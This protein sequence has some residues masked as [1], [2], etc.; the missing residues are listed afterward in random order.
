MPLS[1]QQISET[2]QRLDAAEQ[3][4]QQTGLISLAYPNMT[5]G[6]AYAIQAGWVA[7]KRL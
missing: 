3:A 5:M 7:H 2:A 4:R 1:P 6:D